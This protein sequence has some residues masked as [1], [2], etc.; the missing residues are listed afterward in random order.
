MGWSLQ[1]LGSH[2]VKVRVDDAIEAEHAAKEAAAAAA[3]GAAV[4]AED[5][6]A[7]ADLKKGPSKKK[8]V[9]VAVQINRR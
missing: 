2:T 8:E 3:T 5:A 4:D 6:A 7:A 9:K 1:T